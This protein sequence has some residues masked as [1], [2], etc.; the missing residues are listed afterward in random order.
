M[1]PEL[2]VGI[3]IIYAVICGFFCTKLAEAKNLSEGTWFLVGF[4]FGII[5]LI[6]LVG[7]PASEK[8]HTPN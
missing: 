8:K 4:F 6:A 7:W 3:F 1:E 2:V 5:A